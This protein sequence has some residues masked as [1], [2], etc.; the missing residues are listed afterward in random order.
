MGDIFDGKLW[1]D[2]M[3]IDG[4]PFLSIPNNLVLR[5]NIDSFRVYEHSQYSAGPINLV[6]LNLPRNERCKKENIILTG[7]IPGP[8]EPKCVHSFLAP[9]GTGYAEL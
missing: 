9:L 1:N 4:R 3:F 7:I 8:K 2:L 6:I 5:I